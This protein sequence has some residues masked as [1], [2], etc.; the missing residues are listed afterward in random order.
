[1]NFRSDFRECFQS[2]SKHQRR[3]RE[4][5]RNTQDELRP[6]G[7][8]LHLDRRGLLTRVPVH[9]RECNC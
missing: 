1:M 8:L 9:R 3:I 5:T 7:C 4:R 2:N 6:Q